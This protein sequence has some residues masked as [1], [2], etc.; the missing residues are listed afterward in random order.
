MG[1]ISV[2]INAFQLRFFD[3]KFVGNFHM[4][5]FFLLLLSHMPVTYEA[6]IIHSFISKKIA[7]K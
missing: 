5:S 1:D 3:M 2:A 6:V 7:W 4:M